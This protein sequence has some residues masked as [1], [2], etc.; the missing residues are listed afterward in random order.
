MI[1]PID[2]SEAISSSDISGQQLISLQRSSTSPVFLAARAVSFGTL[3]PANGGES[4]GCSL[5]FIFHG[6]VDKLHS[7]WSDS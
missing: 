1:L 3:A 7:G 4:M 5:E 6:H 2:I